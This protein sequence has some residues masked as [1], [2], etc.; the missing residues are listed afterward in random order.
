MRDLE[1]DPGTDTDR[2]YKEK[3]ELK[4]FNFFERQIYYR[5]GKTEKSRQK[6]CYHVVLC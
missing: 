4:I 6:Y 1:G 3:K 5:H 2:K